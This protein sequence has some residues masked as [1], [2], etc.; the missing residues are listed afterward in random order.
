[1]S[2]PAADSSGAAALLMARLPDVLAFA[3]DNAGL[4]CADLARGLR[5][6]FPGHHF[7]VCGEDEVSPR[8]KAAAENEV[9]ALYLLES[10]GHCPRFTDDPATATG[11]V[12][13]LCA[14]G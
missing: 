4:P 2:G 1:M 11:V 5:D 10:G 12:V 13:A 14:G 7:T 3:S 9:A 8:L 6:R